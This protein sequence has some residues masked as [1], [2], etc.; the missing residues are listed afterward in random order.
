MARLMTPKDAYAIMNLLVKE[1]TGQQA[2]SVVDSS[3]FVSAGETLL[4]SGVENTLNSLSIV[5][6][7][8]MVSVRPYTAKLRLIQ[9]LN[10]GAYTSRF[11]KIS[12]YSKENQASGDWNTDLHARNLY[13]GYDNMAQGTGP[14]DSVASQ[15]VQ[16][17]PVPLELNFGGMSVCETSLTIYENQLQM[18]FRSPDEFIMFYNG[19]M[20]NKANE[21]ERTKEAWNRMNVLNYIGGLYDMAS[22]GTLRNMTSEYNLAFGTTY[23]SA[24]LRTTYK[25]SFL[26]FFIAEFRKASNYMTEDT[27]K[28]HWCPSVTRDGA[29]YSTLIRHTPYAK[30]RVML[31][32][33]F[34][35]EAETQ[36]MP[37]I[38][39]PEYLDI[40][41]QYE[42]VSYWQANNADGDTRAAIDVIPAIPNTA[43]PT[44]Q[45]AG[46][47][48]SLPYVLGILYDEDALLTDFQFESSTKT[49]LE[50][51]KRYYNI[52]WHWSKNAIND[53]TENGIL[54]YMKD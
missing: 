33:P 20:T 31:Y 14:N 23:T 11:R 18:A 53:F 37:E 27:V 35:I 48:V 45:K 6:G 3:T 8:T 26:E 7:R 29:T 42:G 52:F 50:A 24:Q 36:V 25:K 51:R 2:I 34:F 30:Q 9:A 4:A 32:E 17:K 28:Y 47:E 13:N 40:K 22:T 10:T 46:A 1:G 19:I 16:N 43:D 39:N 21:I 15:W 41:T 54:F 12:Y 5:M 38:F 49:P 44:A